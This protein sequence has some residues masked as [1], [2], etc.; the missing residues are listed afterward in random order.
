[1]GDGRTERGL[2]GAHRVDVDELMVQ[3]DIGELIHS[4]LGHLEPVTGP[5]ARPQCGSVGLERLRSLL[6]HGRN[7]RPQRWVVTS[8]GDAPISGM[9]ATGG[10]R[11]RDWTTMSPLPPIADDEI[12]ATLPVEADVAGVEVDRQRRLA[13]LVLGGLVVIVALLFLADALRA[14]PT[15][16][17]TVVALDTWVPY[18]TLDESLP[19]LPLRAGQLREVSPFWY[20]AT[21][22]DAIVVDPNA[23]SGATEDFIEA[24]RESGARVV[25][26]IVDSMPAGGM[27]AVLGNPVTRATHVETLRRFAADGEFAGLD[28]DYEQ[29][30]FTDDRST[31]ATIRPNWVSFITELADV[32]HADDRTLAVSI[33]PVYDAGRTSDS[34]YWVYDYGAIAPVVDSIR[35]MAYDFSTGSAGP[36]A[37]LDFVRRAI[38]GT[39]AASGAPEKLVLGIPLYGYNWPT[40]TVGTC[41][42]SATDTGRT[43]VT[44]RSVTEL[45]AKRGGTPAFDA[46]TGEW[47][48]AYDLVITDD[49]TSC[50]QRR[51]VHYVDSDGAIQRIRL[52][53]EA[54]LGGVS[55]WALGYENADFWVEFV[56][57]D[58]E[59]RAAGD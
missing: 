55:L 21:S 19:E 2:G 26:S 17:A 46:V 1:M 12:S 13:A 9:P 35:V 11:P 50:T 10:R 15:R 20:A 5:L 28:I 57:L 16:P 24:A 43:S 52:A 56:A 39:V 36:V 54:R 53:A 48:F 25:P 33:P 49:T 7:R 44:P 3:G 47:S 18:W 42:A 30:A 37:P 32:L 45:A 27:A 31:W 6:T 14:D 51:Q 29:F 4:L 59:L 38:A 41:P 22:A 23:P 40:N 58:A 8:S 34:G